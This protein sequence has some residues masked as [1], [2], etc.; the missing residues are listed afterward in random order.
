MRSRPARTNTP[1]RHRIAQPPVRSSTDETNYESSKYHDPD[2]PCK[3]TPRDPGL[4]RG[5]PAGGGTTRAFSRPPTK[6]LGQNAAELTTAG[7]ER[8][9]DARRCFRVD[10]PGDEPG[11]FEVAETGG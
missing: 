5:L 7:R 9:L 11:L 10:G 3:R 4:C 6:E 1:R 8:V 2:R